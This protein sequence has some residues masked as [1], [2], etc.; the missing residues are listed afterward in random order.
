MSQ[1]SRTWWGQNF[2]EAIE[3]LTD[4][5][6]LSRGRSYAR[7]KKVLSFDIDG[8]LVTAQVRGSVNPYF[9][10]YSEPLYFTTIEFQPLS[11]AKWSAAVALIASKASLISRLLLNEIPDNIEDTFKQLN[12]NLLPGSRKDFKTSCSCPDYSNPCKHI[13]GVYYLVAAELDQDPFLLFELR[14]LSR[15]ELLKEL[16]KS[17]LGQALS[18]ELQLEQQPPRSVD[19]Y[20]APPE[21]VKIPAKTELREFWQ[22][23]KRLPQTMEVLPDSPVSGIPVKKQGDFPAFWDRDNS[24][25][26]AMETLYEQVKAK[27]QL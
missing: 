2:I 8:G 23:A 12:L 10:V 3:K 19:S 18:A 16:A 6:R 4:S 25:I 11:K 13:A 24:F 9:G 27:G 22:G 15:E 17:P 21:L 20:Y 7:G 1:F 26:E 14:G 5:G